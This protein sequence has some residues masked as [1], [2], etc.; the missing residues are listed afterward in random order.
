MK[1]FPCVA[2]LSLMALFV[3]TSFAQTVPNEECKRFTV[4]FDEK[5]AVVPSGVYVGDKRIGTAQLAEKGSAGSQAFAICIDSK[6]AGTLESKTILYVSGDKLIA[7]N[8]WAIGVNLREGGSLKGFPSRNSVYMY[9]VRVLFD[10]VMER[11][12]SFVR[13]QLGSLFGERSG[14]NKTI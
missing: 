14:Q 11:V 2:V 8:V 13:E 1:L 10:T 9:E 6:H 4:V 7:Y 3:T 5:M 12:F